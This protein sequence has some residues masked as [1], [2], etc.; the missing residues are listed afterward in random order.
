[1][2][3]WDYTDKELHKKAQQEGNTLALEII[4]R[5]EEVIES[6]EEEEPDVYNDAFR[7]GYEVAVTDSI[8]ALQ[9]L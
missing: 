3:L 1:M 5:M 2:N 7:E 8:N 6:M 4:E 9:R